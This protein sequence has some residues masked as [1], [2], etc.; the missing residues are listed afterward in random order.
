MIDSNSTALR[1]ALARAIKSHVEM[2]GLNGVQAAKECG[3][4]NSRMSTILRGQVEKV[5]SDA[6]VDILGKLG[7]RLDSVIGATEGHEFTLTLADQGE[8]LP[9]IERPL[10]PVEAARPFV[11]EYAAVNSLDVD[12]EALNSLAEWVGQDADPD[13]DRVIA[14]E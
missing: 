9:E 13:A 1:G 7:Y 4:A 3:I 14:D 12:H 6:L 2:K 11:E 10:N 5:S 8:V